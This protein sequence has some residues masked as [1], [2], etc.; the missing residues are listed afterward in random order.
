MGGGNG[1]ETVYTHAL[2]LKKVRLEQHDEAHPYQKVVK[3][4][5]DL[6]LACMKAIMS[7]IVGLPLQLVMET[8]VALEIPAIA[9]PPPLPANNVDEPEGEKAEAKGRLFNKFLTF[10]LNVLQKCRNLEVN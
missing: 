5:G 1:S 7:I 4:H 8:G 9:P 2:T 10:F 3:M 6:D